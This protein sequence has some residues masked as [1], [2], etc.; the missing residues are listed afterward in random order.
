MRYNIR[1]Y[2]STI[3]LAV[4]TGC[5]GLLPTPT[6]PPNTGIQGIVLLGPMCPVMQEGVPCP[7]EPYPDAV[8]TVLAQDGREVTHIT[9]ID[10]AGR[11]RVALSPGIYTL[12]PELPPDNI[13]PTAGEQMVTVFEGRYTTVEILYDTEIR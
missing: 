3:I 6:P 8:I 1:L 12:Y 5:G 13:F 9:A 11:F 10:A 4:L 7:D 2:L